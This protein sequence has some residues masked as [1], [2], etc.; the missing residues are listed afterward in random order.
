MIQIPDDLVNVP[1]QEGQ[2][3][4]I[5]L[6]TARSTQHAAH[7]TDQPPAAYCCRLAVAALK[8]KGVVSQRY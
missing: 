5:I 2:A 1:L 3:T 6:H 4:T 8:T 7:S